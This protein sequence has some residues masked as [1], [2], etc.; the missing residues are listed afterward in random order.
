M[1]DTVI[2]IDY[3]MGFLKAK[4]EEE[5]PK[6]GGMI[7]VITMTKPKKVGIKEKKK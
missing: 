4:G 2:D 3:V 1:D 5:K 7:M 6:K